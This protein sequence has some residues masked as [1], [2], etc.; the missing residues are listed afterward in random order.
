MLKS[1]LRTPFP[2]M[3]AGLGALLLLPSI[4]SAGEGSNLGDP[5]N[6][7]WILLGFSVVGCLVVILNPIVTRSKFSNRLQEFSLPLI[8]GVTAGLLG[9]NIW[10]EAYHHLVHKTFEPML[11]HDLGHFVSLHFLVNDLFMAFFFGLAAIEIVEALLPGGDLHPIKKAVSPLIGTLGGVL[12][13]VAVYLLMCF[14]FDQGELARGWGIPTATDIALAWLIAKFV[15]G[16]GHPAITFLLLLAIADDGIGLAIIAIAYP[17]P[18]HPVQLGFLA[19]VVLAMLFAWGLNKRGEKNWLS[20]M[21]P[22]AL[23][24]CGLYFAH[25]HPSLAL[26]PIVP[27]MPHGSHD[28]DGLFGASDHELTPYGV[29]PRS[30]IEELKE[31]IRTPVDYGLFLFAFCNAGVAFSEIGAATW[32]VFFSLLVGK[33][34]GVTAFAWVGQRMGCPLPEGMQL[35]HLVLVGLISGMGLTVALFVSTQAF[36]GTLQAEAKMGALFSAAIAIMALALGRH[37]KV[38]GDHE[39]IE[40]TTEREE[41]VEVQPEPTPAPAH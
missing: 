15:F 6:F 4:A 37:L 40:Q 5:Q 17:D 38:F 32:I 10:P 35:K 22:A 25:L 34:L 39:L 21:A 14:A 9:A 18:N 11:S 8:I 41:T 23:S 27:F 36:E 31:S 29:E 7:K 28:P 13:P 2:A 19:F 24:W 16:K 30:T 1:F 26:V 20:Y 33:T 3:A 12:G